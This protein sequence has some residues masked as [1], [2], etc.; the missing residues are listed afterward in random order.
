M[1]GFPLPCDD[2]EEL[3]DLCSTEV[4]QRG[5]F[6]LICSIVT[7]SRLVL[8][9]LRQASKSRDHLLGQGIATLF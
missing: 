6:G 8:L 1:L 7:E 2:G 4:S 9:T 5:V 3:A